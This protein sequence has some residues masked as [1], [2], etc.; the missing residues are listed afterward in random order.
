MS[1]FT[2]YAATAATGSCDP[3]KHVKYNLGMVL[4]VDDFTQEFSYLAGRDQWMVRDLIG[5]GT[6]SGLR[7][8]FEK[9]DDRPRVVVSAGVAVSP[10]GQMIRVP[11]AQCAYLND[12]LKLATTKQ[13][14]IERHLVPPSTLRLYV[15]LCYRDCPTD[16]VPIP[17]EPCR[18]ED[19]L[20]A[21]SRLADDFM[22]ELRLDPPNQMEED[23]VRD[24]LLWLSQIEVSDTLSSTPMKEF[25]EAIRDAS[26]VIGSPPDFMFG[27][28]PESLVVNRQD[29]RRYFGAAYRIWV[30]ELRPKWRPDLLSNWQGC[31]GESESKEI[32]QEE[33]ALLAEVDVPVLIPDGGQNWQVENPD[34]IAIDED[35]R[36]FLI[37]LR[38]LQEWL[39]CSREFGW[40][41]G[42]TNGSVEGLSLEEEESGLEEYVGHPAGAPTYGIVAAGLIRGDNGNGRPQYNSLN[43]VNVA[44]GEITLSFNGYRVPD[45]SFQYIVKTLAVSHADLRSPVV[46]FLEFRPEGF[47]L[48]VSSGASGVRATLLRQLEF[49][50]E[51]SRYPFAV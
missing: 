47:V 6:V 39:F 2:K 34:N 46:R 21:P 43:V 4:G 51:V 14:L 36:P 33:C 17:G 15:V 9:H 18:S 48:R 26:Q 20:M 23:A 24:F 41:A 19:D 28:P 32:P 30:T 50:V 13:E 40:Q 44:A 7:V 37:N 12:W 3:T 45:A 22:L 25:V 1:T 31:C 5:Y 27:S 42:S 29:T 11:T 8:S 10:C 35:S 38:M 49:M 16:K